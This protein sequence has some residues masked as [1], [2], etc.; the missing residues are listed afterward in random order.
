ML[1][2]TMYLTIEAQPMG[3]YSPYPLQPND[4]S[5]RHNKERDTTDLRDDTAQRH[6]AVS[7]RHNEE[8]RGK[9]HKS[10][11]AIG[12]SIAI[13][14]IY[15]VRSTLAKKSEHGSETNLSN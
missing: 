10:D 11:T 5:V 12:Y 4:V 15:R 14:A 3:V 7:A 1:F 8:R 9:T 6:G 2:H 13:H